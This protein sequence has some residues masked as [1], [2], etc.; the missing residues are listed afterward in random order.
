M[1]SFDIP[2]STDWLNTS[3]PGLSV[4]ENALHCQICKEFFDT[5]MI[6]S[7]CHTFCSKCIRTALS[8][9]GKCPACR[10]SDQASKLRNNWQL[11]EIV[12]A[13]IDTR[14]ATITVAREHKEGLEAHK[15]LVESKKRDASHLNTESVGRTTRSKSRRISS[16]ASSVEYHGLDTEPEAD[17]PFGRK[18]RG[19]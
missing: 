14:P 9:E 11:Q 10:A 2:D 19:D 12:T 7:C 18:V 6:T 1:E 5:P 15:T 16:Q 8:S 3:I 13:F 4:L 17:T